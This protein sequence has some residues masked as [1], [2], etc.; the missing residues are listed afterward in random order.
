VELT[1]VEPA[2]SRFSPKDPAFSS[3]IQTYASVNEESAPMNY[4]YLS[5]LKTL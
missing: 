5:L 2:T 4:G 1:G 3:Q